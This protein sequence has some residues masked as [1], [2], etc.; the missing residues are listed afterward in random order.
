MAWRR[1]GDKP[2]SEP[3]MAVFRRIYASLGLMINDLIVLQNGIVCIINGVPPRTNVDRFYVTMGILSSKRIYNYTI[4]LFMYKYVNGILPELF[5]IFSWMF[6]ILQVCI[7]IILDILNEALSMSLSAASQED[8]SLLATVVLVSG[9]FFLAVWRRILQLVC[10]Q[11]HHIYCFLN[12]NV[13]LIVEDI[14][15]F[16][17]QK[18]FMQDNI[19]RSKEYTVLQ[20]GPVTIGRT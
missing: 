5:D 13:M 11:L 6:C 16:I 8:N 14:Y 17:C 9:T 4:G 7:S 15:L 20:Y 3:I 10:S 2:L 1:P 19:F 12:E 18:I